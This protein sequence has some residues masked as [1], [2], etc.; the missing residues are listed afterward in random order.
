[1]SSLMEEVEAGVSLLGTLGREWVAAYVMAEQMSRRVFEF[2][3]ANPHDPLSLYAIE[4]R[5]TFQQFIVVSCQAARGTS[6]QRIRPTIF[7]LL[8]VAAPRWI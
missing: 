5:G 7:I 2:S 1:M 3:T 4:G 6:G 8:C